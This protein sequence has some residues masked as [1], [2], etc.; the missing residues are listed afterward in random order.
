[1]ELGGVFG[2]VGAGAF[3]WK[4]EIWAALTRENKGW[5]VGAAVGG[6]SVAALMPHSF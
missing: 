2:V 1:L 6:E 5:V 4:F 3:T